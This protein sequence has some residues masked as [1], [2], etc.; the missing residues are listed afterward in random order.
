MLDGSNSYTK[1]Y[2][3]SECHRVVVYPFLEFL[4]TGIYVLSKQVLHFKTEILFALFWQIWNFLESHSVALV[5]FQ[6]FFEDLEPVFPF[7]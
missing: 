1:L 6:C 3:D 2:S 5:D 4:D 7:L